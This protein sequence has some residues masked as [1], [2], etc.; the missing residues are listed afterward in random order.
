[1]GH[2]F[3]YTDS[4]FVLGVNNGGPVL[5]ARRD[6]VDPILEEINGEI[7]S[8]RKSGDPL[9]QAKRTAYRFTYPNHYVSAFEAK[10]NNSEGLEIE[11]EIHGA[12]VKRFY[13]SHVCFRATELCGKLTTELIDSVFK[14]FLSGESRLGHEL[15]SNETTLRIFEKSP[16][17]VK[18]FTGR[19]G[20]DTA[21]S[22]LLKTITD[23]EITEKQLY[24]YNR[25][26]NFMTI[27]RE[28]CY[29]S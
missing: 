17:I 4:K 25:Q 14:I 11:K 10:K 7:N 9:A 19:S 24:L 28:R 8:M 5:V 22:C 6:K 1:V 20:G 21:G 12:F 18:F 26:S 13:N 27:T 2:Y 15:L 23:I 3:V 29:T 16:S